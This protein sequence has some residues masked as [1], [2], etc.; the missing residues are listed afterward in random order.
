MICSKIF[1]I[2]MN[3]ERCELCKRD[4]HENIRKAIGHLETLKLQTTP[5]AVPPPASLFSMT[6]SRYGI[7]S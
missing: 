1:K 2:Y 7:K 3:V 6:A 4:T 5:N